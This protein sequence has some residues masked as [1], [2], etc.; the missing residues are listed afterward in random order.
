MRQGTVVTL[1]FSKQEV[2]D[3]LELMVSQTH[4]ALMGH[5]SGKSD[6]ELVTDPETGLTEV[7]VMFHPKT[8][9]LS[10]GQD[11]TRIF[12]KVDRKV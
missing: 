6:L 10:S 2:L 12:R 1:Y 5:F 3:A 8:S 4:P 7:A 11:E 9:T